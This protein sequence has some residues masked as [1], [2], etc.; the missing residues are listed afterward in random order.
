[1]AFTPSGPAGCLLVAPPELARIIHFNHVSTCPLRDGILGFENTGEVAS[2][3]H[4]SMDHDLVVIGNGIKDDVRT[5]GD[6][7]EAGKIEFGTFSPDQRLICKKPDTKINPIQ[8]PVSQ[9]FLNQSVILP[10]VDQITARGF[11]VKDL[12]HL[13]SSFG[14]PL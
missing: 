7:A 14:R 13:T 5:N 10:K 11:R 4:D 8:D 3:I 12:S 6:A 2:A 9:G 1:M